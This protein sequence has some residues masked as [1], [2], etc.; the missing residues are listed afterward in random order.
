MLCF[1][2]IL[3]KHKPFVTK[4]ISEGVNYFSQYFQCK[5]F[6]MRKDEVLFIYI[7]IYELTSTYIGFT[8]TKTQY[9]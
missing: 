2:I 7:H 3:V 4:I 5:L 9:V 1:S 6:L 8:T